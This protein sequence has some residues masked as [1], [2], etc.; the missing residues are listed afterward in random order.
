MSVIVKINGKIKLFIKGADSIIKKRLASNQVYMNTID[1]HLH[2]FAVK[3]LRTL[4]I[5]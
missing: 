2:T 4:L 3:G 5:A 1:R